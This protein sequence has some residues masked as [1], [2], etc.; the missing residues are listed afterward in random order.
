M[1]LD[2]DPTDLLPIVA[3]AVDAVVAR[4]D[5]LGERLGYPE[6]EAARLLGVRPYV[7]RD[8]RYRG[9]IAARKVG[10]SYI[11]SRAALVRWLEA[12]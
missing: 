6:Q 11:Y 4:R 5:E 10:R 3:A 7:L 1:R 9:E 2:I 12:K 8:A